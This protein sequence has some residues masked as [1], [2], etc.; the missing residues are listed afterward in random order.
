MNN[1]ELLGIS[2]TDDLETVKKA[3]A[4]KSRQ[5]H[6]ETHPEEFQQLYRAYKTIAAGINSNPINTTV[7]TDKT[8]KTDKTNSNSQPLPYKR[9]ASEILTEIETEAVAQEQATLAELEAKRKADEAAQKAKQKIIDDNT[10]IEWIDTESLQQHAADYK[11][12][13]LDELEDMLENQYYPN[14]WKRY[15][16]RDEF[17]DNQYNPDYIKALANAID[18]RIKSPVSDSYQKVGRCPQYAYIYIVIAYGCMFPAVGTLQIKEHVYNLGLLEP[19]Q[20]A[21]R[22][23]D[24][25]FLSYFLIEKNEDLLGDRFA[26]YVYRNVLEELN[27]YKPDK[28]TLCQWIAWGLANEHYACLLDICHYSPS[29]GKQ[30]TPGITRFND[31]IKRSP[32]IF[33]LMS[34]ILEKPGTPPAFKTILREVCEAYMKNAYCC[35]EIRIL[36]LM[37]LE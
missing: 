28:N 5:Y 18:K 11:R 22:L 9:S 15:F 7:K 16:T 23:Y 34:Y 21:F 4:K 17:L 30:I 20:K 3:Y 26:F 12:F 31:K 2:P 33:E 37:T 1:W 27:K 32:L 13:K 14:D 10:F 19:L 25:M 35:D 8:D 24:S 29:H 36:H 6:P